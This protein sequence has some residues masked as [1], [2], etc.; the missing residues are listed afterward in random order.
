MIKKILV[1]TDGSDHAN[2]AIDLAADLAE[3][4]QAQIV[5]LHVMLDHMS[6]YDLRLLAEKYNAG[7]EVL[8]QL[9]E[10]SNTML[11]ATSAGYGGPIALPAPASTVRA[12]ADAICD[13]AVQRAKSKSVKDI[14]A[15]VVGGAA[16]DAILETADAEGVDM[17]VMGSRGL[18]KLSQMLMGSVS[19][20]VSHFSKCTCVTVK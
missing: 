7:Q 1:P 6:V 20:K 18:G 13:V 14:T 15:T 10:V 16:A 3:K 19:H 12:I 9:D 8:D 5:L 17:I 11:E 2:K 4:Y